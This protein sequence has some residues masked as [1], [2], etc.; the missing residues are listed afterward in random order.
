M[1]RSGFVEGCPVAV[2]ALEMAPGSETLR[3]A[4]DAM[5]LGWQDAL[6]HHLRAAGLSED[7]ATSLAS[8]SVSILEGA[9]ILSRTSM[10]TTPLEIA[11]QEL[12]SLVRGALPQARGRAQ[13]HARPRTRSSGIRTAAARLT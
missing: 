7:R 10:T 3:V 4:C 8:L 11:G 9:L 6:R 5:F 2:T 13:A 1:E 12:A